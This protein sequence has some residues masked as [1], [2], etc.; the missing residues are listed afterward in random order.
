METVLPGRH[1][2]EHVPKLPD[3][4]FSLGGGQMNGRSR[5]LQSEFAV[6]MNGLKATAVYWAPVVGMTRKRYED[7][8][9]EK[10]QVIR[11]ADG[12][13]KRSLRETSVPV[14]EQPTHM[15]V[16]NGY[17]LRVGSFLPRALIKGDGKVQVVEI[18]M[19]HVRLAGEMQSVGF[20][21]RPTKIPAFTN[22]PVD[23]HEVF[24]EE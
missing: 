11:N 18:S 6:Q 15:V 17:V 2:A 1:V 5:D 20:D 10:G 4:L 3:N 24:P 16:I 23:A 13:P 19:S 22:I 14:E 8:K 21:G 9:D 7:V 12:S